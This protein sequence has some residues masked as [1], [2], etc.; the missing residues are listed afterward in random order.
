[1]DSV[2]EVISMNRVSILIHHL[3]I[4]NKF[5]HRA[6]ELAERHRFIGIGLCIFLVIGPLVQY[7]EN[8]ESIRFACRY[9]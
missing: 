9:L 7:R 5:R 8:R 1:M 3:N 4:D 6:L 2:P